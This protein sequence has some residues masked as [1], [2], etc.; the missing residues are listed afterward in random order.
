MATGL[1]AQITLIAA[2]V[3]PYPLSL[4]QPDVAVE[5]TEHSLERLAADNE[6]VEI[7]L[8]RD[9]NETIRQALPPD[10]VAIVGARQRRWWPSWWLSADSR[11]V[12][13][14]RRD[15]RRVV[16]VGI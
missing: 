5:F 10:S 12:R 15:G 3:I 4:A 11:L 1:G 9:R 6:K 2:Q 8:C 16:V 13:W 7:Y 14:L